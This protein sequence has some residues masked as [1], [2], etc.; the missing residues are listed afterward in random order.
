MSLVLVIEDDLPVRDVLIRALKGDGYESAEAANGDEGIAAYDRLKPDVVVTDIMMPG[1]YGL[2]VVRHI[3]DAGHGTPIIVI[4]GYHPARLSMADE[5]GA[6]Y[7]F[8]K[9][10]E[11]TAFLEAVSALTR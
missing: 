10:F 3:W 4:S 7:T 2:Q 8:Q 1:T 11:I 5:L 6:A 9:P